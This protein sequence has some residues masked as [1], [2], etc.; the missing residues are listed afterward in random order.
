[1]HTDSEQRVVGAY[2]ERRDELAV[3]LKSAAARKQLEEKWSH[4]R[5]FPPAHVHERQSFG[6]LSGTIVDFEWRSF[7]RPLCNTAVMEDDD[8]EVWPVGV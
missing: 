7:E 6:E 1:M 2:I 8:G 4:L 3:V 5:V